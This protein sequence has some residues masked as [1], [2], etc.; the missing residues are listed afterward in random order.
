MAQFS[1]FVE[2]VIAPPVAPQVVD[3]GVRAAPT[4]ALRAAKSDGPRLFLVY[5]ST[6]RNAAQDVV[7]A[8]RLIERYEA[9]NNTKR[10]ASVSPRVVPSAAHFPIPHFASAA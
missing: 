10:A 5:S 9:R 2:E 8:L 3:D 4:G 1:V 7:N 6:A